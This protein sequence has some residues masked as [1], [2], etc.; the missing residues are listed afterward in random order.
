MEKQERIREWCF[1]K[2]MEIFTSQESKCPS[3]FTA[4]MLVVEARILEAYI[5]RGTT[6]SIG[7]GKDKQE[8]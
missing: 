2:A 4:D 5:T 3:L 6:I 7:K 1:E 8:V